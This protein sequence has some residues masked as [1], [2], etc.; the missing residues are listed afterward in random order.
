MSKGINYSHACLTEKV[1]SI[2]TT[3]I[4][5]LGPATLVSIAMAGELGNG[6]S[7]VV[8][9]D[10]ISNLGVGNIQDI[11]RK[12]ATQD[13]VDDFYDKIADYANLKGV[14]V[15]LTSI[16]GEEC[17]LETLMT[18]S[19]KTGGNVDIIDP[20]LAED[21]FK[22]LVTSKTIAT[23]VNVKIVLHKAL[24][25]KNES[26][27]N[28]NPQKNILTKNL[29]NVIDSSEITFSYK[30]KDS[31]ELKKIEGFNI[32]TLNEIPFQCAIEYTTL[33]GKKCIRTITQVLKTSDDIEEVKKDA[34]MGILA[35]T[36]A[37]QATNLVREGKFRE[38]QAYSMNNKRYMKN[39]LKSDNDKRKYK[40][41]KGSM[42]GM[43]GQIHEQNNL[44]E[45]QMAPMMGDSKDTAPTKNKKGFFSKMNDALS[46]NI[47]KQS[48]FTSAN[49]N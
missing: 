23:K 6:A 17:D 4:T 44:E 5:A 48:R 45:M 16:Q 31:E 37:H 20:S 39:N 14:S 3:G 7:V 12:K 18:L 49:L 8:C 15:S 21:H 2:R 19:D 36:A 41:Y 13:E 11:K 33:D 30:I 26:E 34:N 28:L 35:V 1:A 46:S 29:G 32:E 43:Y 10:G 27:K 47:V 25:F 42:K 24:E 22:N 38:A 40:A 9:T